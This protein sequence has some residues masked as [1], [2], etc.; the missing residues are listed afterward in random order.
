M[1]DKNT[2]SPRSQKNTLKIL[3]I[4]AILFLLGFAF[5]N[6]KYGVN[7]RDITDQNTAAIT[8]WSTSPSSTAKLGS[9]FKRTPDL[10]IAILETGFLNEDGGFI[11]SKTLHTNLPGA[12]RIKIENT[13]K[14]MKYS[15][16]IEA[17]LPTREPFTYRSEDFAPLLKK[18]VKTFML[19]FDQLTTKGIGEITVRVVTEEKEKRI[20]NNEVSGS[21]SVVR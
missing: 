7:L 9:F 18:E 1:N 12:L 6:I 2:A 11:E 5:W 20:E 13:G 15:W 3:A 17:D 14:D 4:I 8:I 19:S 21:V 10:S 16:Q